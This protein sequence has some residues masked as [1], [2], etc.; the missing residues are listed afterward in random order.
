MPGIYVRRWK[1]RREVA[2][3][4]AVHGMAAYHKYFSHFAK[5]MRSM[6][7]S[8]SALDLRG[9][10]RT[11]GQFPGNFNGWADDICHV[12]RSE[13]GDVPVFL[14]GHS[15]GCMNV[16]NYLRL[17][18]ESGLS[19]L[20]LISPGISLRAYPKTVYSLPRVAFNSVFLPSRMFDTYSSLDR[21]V[22]E[23]EEAQEVRND[24]NCPTVVPYGLFRQFF[25]LQV[26]SWLHAPSIRLPSLIMIGTG[27][28][29]ISW[30]AQLAFASLFKRKRIVLLDGY[31][32][33]LREFLT[34]TI[35]DRKN[36]LTRRRLSGMIREWMGS[37]IQ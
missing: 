17:R 24:R 37:V 34:L 12:V 19:G 36:G 13:S 6:G 11:G 31:D 33:R 8:V 7:V 26:V 4:I 35:T 27:D 21:R 22:I 23:T 28:E 9:Y 2:R 32:H 10:G 16:V 20:I 5:I 1:A 25:F 3:I 29:I 30:R 14:M 18:G 15:M